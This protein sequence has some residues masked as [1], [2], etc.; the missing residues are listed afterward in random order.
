MTTESMRN[1]VRDLATHADVTVHRSDG[2]PADT[3]ELHPHAFRHSL[4]NYMLAD[5]D[6]HLVDVRNRLRIGR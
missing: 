3:E 4:A 2:E 5:E 6:T 1:I